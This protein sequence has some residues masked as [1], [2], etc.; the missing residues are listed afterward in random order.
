[1]N[2]ILLI[3]EMANLVAQVIKLILETN[4]CEAITCAHEDALNCFFDFEPDIILIFDYE[5]DEAGFMGRK[6]YAFL[7][8]SITQEKAFMLGFSSCAEEGFI[9]LPFRI[10]EFK[11]RIGI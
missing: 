5:P 10:D 7:K 1:M 11:K 4:G 6:T 8:D 2:K 9:Q 3:S